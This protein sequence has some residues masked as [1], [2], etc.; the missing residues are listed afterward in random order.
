M[1]DSDP[2][3]DYPVPLFPNEFHPQNCRCVLIITEENWW[4]FVLSVSLEEEF[5]DT[6][7]WIEEFQREFIGVLHG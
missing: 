2:H 4:L 7:P 6:E 1:D 3:D 5:G